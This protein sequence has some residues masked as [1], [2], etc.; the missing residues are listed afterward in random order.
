MLVHVGIME[1]LI[2]GL[3]YTIWKAFLMI[4]NIETR[5]NRLHVPAAVSGLLS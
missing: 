1:L 3:Y 4:I 2:F 5:R